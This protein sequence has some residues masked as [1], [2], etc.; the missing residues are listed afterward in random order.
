MCRIKGEKSEKGDSITYIAVRK[1]H[2]QGNLQKEG[3]IC[4]LLFQNE[5]SYHHHEGTC[6][7]R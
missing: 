2:E 1:Y 7:N 6:D 3:I 4:D 5:Q